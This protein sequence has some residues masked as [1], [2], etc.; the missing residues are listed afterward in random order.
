ME[1]VDLVEVFNKSADGQWMVSD[2]VGKLIVQRF[3]IDEQG[4]KCF[5]SVLGVCLGRTIGLHKNRM[6]DEDKIAA[7]LAEVGKLYGAKRRDEGDMFGSVEQERKFVGARW[8]AK[9]HFS[10]GDG[11]AVS[12]EGV[13]IQEY[14]LEGGRVELLNGELLWLGSCRNSERPKRPF[15][16]V[17]S[18]GVLQSDKTD[19]VAILGLC[20]F[21]FENRLGRQIA[22]G[23]GLGDMSEL[24]TGKSCG[25]KAGGVEPDVQLVTLGMVVGQQADIEL[26]IRAC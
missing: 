7:Q 3:Y 8:Q 1:W 25:I 9:L 24:C 6:A 23:N 17:D 2:A 10:G 13:W 22:G 18:G 12:Q 15:A 5:T 4:L 11:A 26:G 16:G 21:N 19:G 14:P 20:S